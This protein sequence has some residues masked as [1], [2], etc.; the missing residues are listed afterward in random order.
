MTT[1]IS[2]K[3]FDLLPYVRQS[4]SLGKKINEKNLLIDAGTTVKG[5]FMSKDG[6][7][8][9]SVI[10][11]K[12]ISYG[13]T[14]TLPGHTE[15]INENYLLVKINTDGSFS[16]LSISSFTTSVHGSIKTLNP[17]YQDIFNYI[18]INIPKYHILMNGKKYEASFQK[19]N[20]KT[21]QLEKVSFFKFNNDFNS[22]TVNESLKVVEFDYDQDIVL[23][24]LQEIQTGGIS[25]KI[26]K[27]AVKKSDVT[28]KAVKKSDVPKKAVKKSD[29][30]KK[31]V[32]KSDVPKKAVKK[33]DVPKKA[34]KKSDV[35]KKAVKK[36]DV[37]K[38]AVKKSDVPKKAVKK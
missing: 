38:K 18:Y 1:L 14:M 36:S 21:G 23:L 26:I 11:T 37:P 27:K 24:T 32:K 5:C 9:G 35:P 3:L 7:S 34:V 6:I 30:P 15:S 20:K 17:S 19:Q 4:Y 10:F 31:A 28:K 12:G 29:V 2:A 8:F 16:P 25:M 22:Y 33:S 13:Y